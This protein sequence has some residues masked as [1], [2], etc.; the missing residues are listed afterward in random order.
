MGN[1]GKKPMATLESHPSS[2]PKVM[3]SWISGAWKQA[4]L[5]VFGI[6]PEGAPHVRFNRLESLNNLPAEVKPFIHP[7]T[8][9]KQSIIPWPVSPWDRLKSL[10]PFL[11]WAPRYH[12]TWLI[13][14]LIAG[15]TLALVLI[16]QGMAYAKLAQLPIQ[17]GL[18]SS[19]MGEG[20]YWLFGTSKD[21]SVGPVA[22][23][24][25]FTGRVAKKVAN[26]VSMAP[27]LVASAFA[28]INGVIILV[29][30]LLNLGF[31][32]DF[33]STPSSIA[34]VTS[35]A[36][37][38]AS[39][40]FP[41]LLGLSTRVKTDQAPY[42][43]IIEVLAN[44]KHTKIDG[45]IGLSALVFLYIIRFGLRSLQR[46]YPSKIL[47]ILLSLRVVFV[48]TIYTIISFALNRHR[49]EKTVF[50]VVAHVPSGLTAAGV[51]AL[52]PKLLKEFIGDIPAQILILV[53]EHISI[54][55][56]F[57]RKNKYLVVPSQELVALGVANISGPL[58]GGFVT[59]GSFSRTAIKA[60]IQVR[61][62][63]ASLFTALTVL[64]ALYTL[65]GVFFFIPSAALSAVIIHGVLDLITSPRAIYQ[66][67]W[68]MEKVEWMIFVIGVLLPIFTSIEIG[69]YTTIGLSIVYL[70]L[71]LSRPR[72]QIMGRLKAQHLLETG[73]VAKT[74]YVPI[75]HSDGSNPAITVHSPNHGTLIYRFPDPLLFPNAS[76]LIDGIIEHVFSKTSGDNL[77][78]LDIKD[79]WTIEKMVPRDLASL[80]PLKGVILDMSA[81]SR[82]DVSAAQALLRLN[83]EIE[84]Y[85]S[86]AKLI[87]CAVHSN[88]LLQQ[89][90]R[91]RLHT[92]PTDFRPR[93]QAL[94]VKSSATETES[95][96]P[97]VSSSPDLETRIDQ[98]RNKDNPE[99][100]KTKSPVNKELLYDADLSLVTL[101]IDEGVKLL[102]LQ[103][104]SCSTAEVQNGPN[105]A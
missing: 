45:L 74:V 50:K 59:T 24:S 16:P 2:Q 7:D 97:L 44:L 15:I 80:P 64:L 41:S 13:G 6:L 71:R 9:L 47:Q 31:V 3:A 79:R 32:L 100:S 30:G 94:V 33:V 49:R 37:T 88:R 21:I 105:P 53:L 4:R 92:S 65:T 84:S 82:L 29:L 14:D 93:S 55:K 69:L 46:R 87:F 95:S 19:V 10:V 85:R 83:R 73:E 39:D 35:S 48:L 58:L 102:E 54:C 43:I 70:L 40:Q 18:Y 12:L 61:T 68:V 90:V 25:Q 1:A 22:V 8:S 5:L 75:D 38:I 101:D 11:S 26:E 98:S 34:F 104:S 72:M 60:N 62:P 28:L 99:S 86:E 51:P 96:D 91:L 17:Y 57:G 36:I 67:L 27:A 89:I 23:A 20:S 66:K 76:N 63:L 81:V 42:L 78:D 56:V 77:E 103:I 52:N